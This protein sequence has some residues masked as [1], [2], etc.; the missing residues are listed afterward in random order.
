VL[1]G[2]LKLKPN[3]VATDELRSL[4]ISPYFSEDGTETIRL[5]K[6]PGFN[7]NS[8]DPTDAELLIQFSVYLEGL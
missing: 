7:I 3:G 4:T 6:F 8:A 1:A 2:P 5:V